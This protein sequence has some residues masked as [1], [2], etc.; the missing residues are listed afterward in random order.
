MDKITNN[1]IN[2]LPKKYQTS[3]GERG[4]EEFPNDTII[5]LGFKQFIDF[6]KVFL[7]TPS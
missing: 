1:I 2:N 3:I 7:P 4:P 5:P 6:S